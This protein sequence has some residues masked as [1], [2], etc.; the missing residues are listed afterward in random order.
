MIQWLGDVQMA[1]TARQITTSDGGG[2]VEE[3]W[4]FMVND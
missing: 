2:G 4:R 3:L 1:K